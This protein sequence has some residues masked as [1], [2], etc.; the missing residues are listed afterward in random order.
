[1]LPPGVN[2]TAVKYTHQI[3][4]FAPYIINWLVFITKME[5][6]CSLDLAFSNYDER[7][8]NEMRF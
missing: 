6:F 2:P 7:K 1:M 4:T 3:A 5:S 8:S